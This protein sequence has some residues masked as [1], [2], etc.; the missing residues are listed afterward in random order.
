LSGIFGTIGLHGVPVGT[1]LEAMEQAM[2]Y[3]GPDG[4]GGWAQGTAGLGH[5]KLLA[6]PEAVD[7]HLPIQDPGSGLV[8][9]ASARLDD[10][11]E[12][13]DALDLLQAERASTPDTTLLLKAWLRW[14]ERA[15]PRLRGDWSFALWDP[16]NQRLVLARDPCGQTALYYASTP[17]RFAFASCQKALLALPDLPRDLDELRLA[18]ILTSWPGDGIATA[19]RAI[20][21]L[22]WAHLLRWEDGRIRVEKYWSLENAPD[23]RL[24]SDDAYVEAFLELYTRAVRSRL[25]AVRPVGSTLSAGL[26]SGSVTVLSARELQAQ[27]A[28]L[29]AFTSV[30][31]YPPDGAGPNRLG[32]EW[33]LAQAVAARWPSITHLAVSAAHSTPLDGIARQLWM[34]DEPGH[35]AGNFFWISALLES[36]RDHRLGVLL[37][38]Q[39]GNLAVSWTGSATRVWD[40]F[41]SG[42]LTGAAR[43][44]AAWKQ[45]RQ[46]S[47]TAAF[48]SQIL[49]PLLRPLWVRRRLLRHPFR[50]VWEPYSAIH[51]AFARRLGLGKLMRAA[52]HD[53]RFGGLPSLAKRIAFLEQ[54][55]GIVGAIWHETGAAYGLEVRDPTADSRLLEFCLGT[56]DDQFTRR[57]QDRWLNRR[58]MEGLLPSEVQWNHRRGLQAADLGHRLRAQAESCHGWLDSMDQ[59][60]AC[61]ERLDLPRMRQIL[62]AL[63]IRVDSDGTAQGVTV[64][65]RGLGVGRFLLGWH[66]SLGGPDPEVK[67]EKKDVA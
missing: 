7:E 20:R 48:K 10:R 60:A 23:I 15:L 35:A 25:R 8:F 65:T 52:G 38:G 4:R 67:A 40:E 19:Y 39:M 5:L 14:D 42:N 66:G 36:A 33:P 29:I 30:P 41:W 24:G 47:W 51:P 54:G 17:G 34:A 58:A 59:S 37:T 45:A 18:Q 3:W 1:D 11:D 16:R 49:R 63:Q 64:L 6:T 61:R 13:C 53:P 32:D 43:E 57:G 28:P 21:R 56:P 2:A 26:D 44:L 46:R 50:P 62:H 31:L 27:G 12:L 55:G 9:T 22:P